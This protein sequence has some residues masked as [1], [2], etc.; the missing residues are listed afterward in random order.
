MSTPAADSVMSLKMPTNYQNN[1]NIEPPPSFLKASL[2][3][4]ENLTDSNNGED[5]I[6]QSTGDFLEFYK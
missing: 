4:T 5:M 6:I 2:L 1:V 3:V